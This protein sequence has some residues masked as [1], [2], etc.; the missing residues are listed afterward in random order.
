M[1]T[2]QGGEEVLGNNRRENIL[3]Y[4]DNALGKGTYK[5]TSR[6]PQQSYLCPFC[7]DHKERMF[8]NV[9]RQVY[10]CHN[11]GNKG[12]LVSFISDYEHIPWEDALKVYRGYQGYERQLPDSI[13]DEIY[14]KLNTIPIIDSP[15]FVYPL[16][17]EFIP[18]QEAHGKAGEIAV[19]YVRSRGVS[20]KMAEKYGVGYCAE[21]KY[22]DRLI[23]PDFE[24]GELVFW[25][26]RTWLPRPSNR[27]KRRFYRKVLNP[28]LTDEQKEQGVIAIDKS[29]VVSNI[30]TILELGMAV[31]CEGK[32]DAFTI[33]D[34]G[35][36]IHGK[37]MSD[38]QFMKLLVNKD[39]IHTVA[40]ML[41]PDAM[42]HA[43]LLAKRLYRH[44]SN[45]L[46]CKLPNGTDPNDIGRKGVLEVL[47]Q[48]EL[49]TPMFE[50]KAR[51]KGWV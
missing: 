46:V 43:L 34:I 40:I 7:N 28:T 38:A 8:V 44:F 18:I 25:Q 27:I 35:G 9:D 45:V 3:G 30:D 14:T 5:N 31:I 6:G 16:P 11:C 17:K 49:Y 50:I 20:L 12:T 19:N 37:Y 23:M 10:F 22:S 13:E 48:A 4:I 29:D 41:D 32:F 42:D 2:E 33:G 47:N 51:L 21:G 24:N 15:K 36:C 1:F 39:K 26:A